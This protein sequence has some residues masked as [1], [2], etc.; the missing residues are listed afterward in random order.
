MK[1][2]LKKIIALMLVFAFV[3]A[4]AACKKDDDDKTTS[5]DEVSSSVDAD[6]SETEDLSED[7]SDDVSEDASDDVSEDASDDVSEDAS[8]DVPDDTTEATT[9]APK[10]VSLPIGGNQAQVLEFY[11]KQGNA[12]KQY[13]GKVKVTKKD[14]T[15]SEINHIAGGSVVK[16]LALSLLPNDY[17]ERD[18]LTF[19]N[20][21][22]GDRKLSSWL[23]RSY[24]D[25]ISEINPGG[26]NGVKSATCT[27]SGSGCKVVIVFNDDKTSGATALSDKPKYVSKAMDTLD[28]KESDLD[29]FVL[30]SAVVN[31]TGCSIEAVFDAEGRIV[32]L[33]ILTPANIMGDL[34]YGIIKLKDSNVV[35]RYKGN[36]T[37]TYL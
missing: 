15:T 29:P 31:Y 16:N 36:Y 13:K 11:N 30:E 24:S 37:F 4:F 28:L 18:T 27:A 5:G 8:D 6:Q 35:G 23:P 10:G 2:T 32:K 26:N 17:A 1:S 33:D 19:N 22:A 12:L 20:G 34:T 21:V 9:A 3:F 7:A 14:G 25:K